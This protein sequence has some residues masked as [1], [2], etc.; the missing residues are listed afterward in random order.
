MKLPRHQRR[1]QEKLV[2]IQPGS[3]CRVRAVVLFLCYLCYSICVKFYALCI[4]P[5]MRKFALEN[6]MKVK[7]D[8]YKYTVHD[9]RGCDPT[10]ERSQSA[11]RTM[12]SKMRER[13]GCNETERT[14]AAA[15]AHA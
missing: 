10:A 11:R 1:K 6:T 3:V 15:S 2:V 5:D 8:R 9:P 12:R 14:A 7:K 4:L 13:D